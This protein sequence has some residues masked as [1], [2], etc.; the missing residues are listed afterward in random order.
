MNPRQ[1]GD[2]TTMSTV[3]I[4]AM[5]A[6]AMGCAPAAVVAEQPSAGQLPDQ[7]GVVAAAFA[8]SSPQTGAADA[9]P[10]RCPYHFD[11]DMP[12]D[13]FCVYR[14]VVR[15]GA[16][17]VCA[18]DV[19]VIWSSVGLQASMSGEPTEKASA[20]NREVYL[21]FVD[22]PELVVHAVVDPRKGDRADMVGYTLGSEEDPHVLGGE[23]TLRAARLGSADVLSMHWRK[24]R[25]FRTGSCAFTWYSGTFLGMIRPP[26]VSCSLQLQDRSS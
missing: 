21:G 19:I 13:T 11:S 24:P 15:G 26:T 4:L 6:I 2:V 1:A 9:T 5:L 16:G 10:E 17:E 7:G 25:P 8:A 3:R 14:G 18:N 22:E 12:A 23:M 20:S